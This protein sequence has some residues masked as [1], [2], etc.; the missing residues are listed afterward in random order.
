[1]SQ[2]IAEKDITRVNEAGQRV[3]VVPKGQPIP[4]D[5][6]EAVADTVPVRQAEEPAP[7]KSASKQSK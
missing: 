6:E 2:K 5:L 7:K 1:M 3:L 4:A